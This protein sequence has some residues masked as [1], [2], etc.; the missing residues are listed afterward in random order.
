MTANG[1][2][3]SGLWMSPKNKTTI[4]MLMLAVGWFCLISMQ[5]S[6]LRHGVLKHKEMAGCVV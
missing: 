2:N 3:G 6:A 4:S 5:M 1:W